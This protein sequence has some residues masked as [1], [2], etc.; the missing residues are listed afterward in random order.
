MLI[1]ESLGPRNFSKVL[2]LL[3]CVPGA[4]GGAQVEEHAAGA[5]PARVATDTSSLLEGR[6]EVVVHEGA[7]VV[8]RMPVAATAA[9]QPGVAVEAV[10]GRGGAGVAARATGRSHCEVEFNGECFCLT[11]NLQMP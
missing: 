2:I 4:A 10:V 11:I 3:N 8:G 7:V 6:Q 1:T 5:S 9:V